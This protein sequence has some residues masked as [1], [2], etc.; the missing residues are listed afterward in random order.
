M[1]KAY[2]FDLG[3]TNA[4]HT[5][6]N[7]NIN[8]VYYQ[9]IDPTTPS[10]TKVLGPFT[11]DL[12][13]AAHILNCF[14]LT[15]CSFRIV[16][17]FYRSK[18]FRY[19]DGTRTERTM[20]ERTMVRNARSSEHTICLLKFRAGSERTMSQKGRNTRRVSTNYADDLKKGRNTRNTATTMSVKSELY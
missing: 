9:S 19:D 8:P 5:T 18:A 20:S 12:K 1:K 6:S 13:L 10:S 2:S 17:F 4:Y 7:R 15:L 16:F 11:F 3:D 14:P